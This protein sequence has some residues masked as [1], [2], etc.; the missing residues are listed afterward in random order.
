MDSV[1]PVRAR[2]TGPLALVFALLLALVPSKE[3]GAADAT[4]AA[5]L[6]GSVVAIKGKKSTAVTYAVDFGTPFVAVTQVDYVFDFGDDLLDPGE[7]L[8]FA[9]DAPPGGSPLGGFCNVSTTAQSGRVVT[10]PRAL[11]P[12]VCDAL[13]DGAVGGQITV[14]SSTLRPNGRPAGASVDLASLTVTVHDG[15]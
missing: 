8:W 2:L 7:C 14:S 13:L 3:T 6:S 9:I 11:D 12:E 4:G 1:R 10:I 15:S 5:T